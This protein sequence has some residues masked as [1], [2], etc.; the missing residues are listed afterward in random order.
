MPRLKSAL[1]ACTA[2]AALSAAGVAVAQEQPGAGASTQLEEVVVTAQRRSERL[3]DVPMQANVMTQETLRQANVRNVQDAISL[4]PNMTL[5][6]ANTYH[7]SY[8]TLRGITQIENADPPVAVIVDGVPQTNQ[9]QVNP[10]L[11]DVKQVEI[12]KGPQGAL[13]GRN[14]E[15]GAINIVTNPPTNDFSGAVSTA[16]SRGN[17]WNVG[18]NVSGP[19][20]PDKLL[21]RLAGEYASSDG[22]IKNT[23]LD[24]GADFIDHDYSVRAR[25]LLTP[26]EKLSIDGRVEYAN[27]RAGSN[28]YSPVFS[29]NPNDFV[30]PQEN[31]PG[32][33]W[34]KN[35]S[36]TAKIDYDLGFATLTGI[37]GYSQVDEDNLSDLDF[38]NPV[39][40]PG[41]FLGLGIQIGVGQSLAAKI[42]SQEVRL[43]SAA[44]GPIRYSVGA[45]YVGTTRYY[46]TSVFVDQGQGG[47]EQFN[48]E[49]LLSNQYTYDDNHAYAGFGQVDFDITD[50]LMLTGGFRY[51]VDERNQ[52]NLVTGLEREKKFQKAQPK[53]TI[54]YKFS[55]DTLA[56]A[57]YGVG[58]RSGGFNTP[59]SAIPIFKQES[60]DNV[61]V[62][63]KSTFLQGR[64]RVNGALYQE[65]VKNYQWFFVDATSGSQ[66]I[67]NID[68]VRIRGAELEVQAAPLEG[69]TVNIGVGYT[70]TNIR[71]FAAAPQ[72]VG[73]KSPRNIPFS[74]TGSVQYKREVRDGTDMVLHADY[75]YNNKKYWMV[76]NGA[77]QHSWTLVNARIGFE[78][79]GAG[80]YIFGK[81][82]T[83]QKHYTEYQPQAYTG[84]DVD[85]GFLGQ[86]RTYGVEL[87]YRF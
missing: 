81:N 4:V 20:V 17:T 22:L 32:V 51:D 54:T 67:G 14:A 80:V 63:L 57:T 65:N 82:L 31:L 74:T 27:F 52:L 9:R 38:R 29:A 60:L 44:G 68:K 18:A 8:I 64:L 23:F 69:L 1:L 19:I 16:Y 85:L 7:S 25:I 47:R 39:Q 77:V 50:K 59:N 56:Y 26:T 79:A 33:S 15:A 12:L 24:R 62:G 83:D 30:L 49:L 10:S 53:A 28:Y 45:Y 37:T 21:F 84:E 86:P 46:R 2:M 72:F 35:Y 5:D 66:V 55:T 3:Q 76:D 48:P 78:R 40:S 34:G 41:G 36:L 87:S 75:Q 13:Y 61:E 71:K 73:N 11:Y 43:V 58:F 6:R 70:D 42:F